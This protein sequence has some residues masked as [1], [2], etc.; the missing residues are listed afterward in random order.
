MSESGSAGSSHPPGL[1]PVP[2]DGVLARH[3][4]LMLLSSLE[5]GQ[6][7]DVLLDLLEQIA[8]AG[9]DGRQFADQVGAALEGDDAEP[10]SS[11]LAFGA[12]GAGL[13]VIVSGGA[14]ADVTTSYG[15]QR[16]EAGQPGMLLR[17]LVRSPVSA[18]RGGLGAA[19]NGQARTDRFSRLDAG[20]VRAGGLSFFSGGAAPSAV[21]APRPTA[22]PEPV[23]REP[24]PEPVVPEPALPEPALP[25]PALP[26]PA[27]PEPVVPEPA[28][29]E[30]VVPEPARPEPVVPEPAL[31]EPSVPEPAVPEPAP[32]DQQEQIG[33]ELPGRRRRSIRR[34]R[35]EGS[36][37]RPSHRSRSSR[38]NSA[39]RQPR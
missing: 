25:E 32:A 35:H 11:V 4:T 28:L 24:V 29:P 23:R 19:D 13:A 9:G 22:A 38:S 16:I 27:L 8:A 1:W 12:A 26:E 34:P 39:R 3:G 33:T 5:S 21:A 15:T 30:P 14:W 10:G 36:P 37:S 7:V 20:T 2:G 18:V 31:P 17:C 6:F